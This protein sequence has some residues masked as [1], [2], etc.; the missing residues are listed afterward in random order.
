MIPYF[1]ANS[2]YE[3]TDYRGYGLRS[4]SAYVLVYDVTNDDSFQY[5]RNI[6]DQIAESRDLH[7]V[8]LVVVGNKQDMG[9]DKSAQKREISNVVR[10]QWKCGY[11]ECSAKHNWH[12]IALFK[13]VMRAVDC[14]DVGHKPTS[15]RVQDAFR[16]NRCVIL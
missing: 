14:N 9:D 12:I 16:R 10:K 2:L 4:A 8:P 5:V 11:I 13:E 7:D 3:W 1:P 15:M 6:H